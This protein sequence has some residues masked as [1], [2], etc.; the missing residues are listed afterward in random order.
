[1]RNLYDIGRDVGTYSIDILGIR[2]LSDASLIDTRMPANVANLRT[3]WTYGGDWKK[4]LVLDPRNNFSWLLGAFDPGGALMI[5]DLAIV[6]FDRSAG[7][8]GFAVWIDARSA[9]PNPVRFERLT[10]ALRPG[11]RTAH[12]GAIRYGGDDAAFNAYRSLTGLLVA[13]FAGAPG[14]T[15]AVGL[16]AGDLDGVSDVCLED[17]ELDGVPAAG[18][19]GTLLRDAGLRFADPENGNFNLRS[20]SPGYGICGARDPGAQDMWAL[21]V[22]H[23]DPYRFGDSWK[24]AASSGSANDT[25]L[26]GV[27]DDA[28]NCPFTVNPSQQDRDSDF[29]G[30]S[31]DL[32][33]DFAGAANRDRDAN[34]IGDVCECGDQSGDGHVDVVDVLAI[35]LAIRD[36]AQASDLCDTNFDRACDVR[37]L[38]G[39]KLKI[40]GGAAYCSRYPPPVP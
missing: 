17:N 24:T 6:G 13:N 4:I 2:Y 37:D 34:G 9:A 15:G 27:S 22:L 19:A 28:D 12:E 39:V 16:A 25:D 40:Q 11:Q 21:R 3:T 18:I 35:N 33:P 26:D 1:V 36:P 10:L 14:G 31:C 29:L 7:T 23:H 30:D 20:D 5:R 32:C 8:K 38:F